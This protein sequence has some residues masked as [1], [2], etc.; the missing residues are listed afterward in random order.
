MAYS[1]QE[2]LRYANIANQAYDS[3]DADGVGTGD[4]TPMREMERTDADNGEGFSAAAYFDDKTGTLVIAF[5]GTEGYVQDWQANINHHGTGLTSAQQRLV[6]QYVRQVRE[7]ARRRGYS[8]QRTVY[9]GHSLGGFLSQ[10]ALSKDTNTRSRAIT[11]NSPGSYGPRDNRAT[12]VYTD[13][14]YWG[15]AGGT[16]H[17]RGYWVS[18]NVYF[19]LDDNA[20]GYR[21]L[22]GGHGIDPLIKALEKNGSGRVVNKREMVDII[23]REYN[24]ANVQALA[25]GNYYAIARV[26]ARYAG[27]PRV[28]DRALYLSNVLY[29]FKCLFFVLFRGIGR[30]SQYAQ[31][32]VRGEEIEA[33]SHE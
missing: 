29:S 24:R 32:H 11:F 17:N 18:E 14:K 8:V 30:R 19:V 23:R 28:R 6:D 10:Y 33:V 25:S 1:K 20:D 3:V 15:Q 9:T 22:T 2:L 27:V 12:Y 16:A 13:P 31:S 21:D 7:E 4:F 5:G 26:D